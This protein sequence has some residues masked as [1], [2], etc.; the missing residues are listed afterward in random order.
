MSDTIKPEEID[1]DAKIDVTFTE[2]G[3]DPKI[4]KALDDLGYV[5][6]TPIQAKGIPAALQQRDVLGIAQTGTG[7]TGAFT[8]PT[9]HKLAKG[10]AR[11]RMPRCIIVCPT[12][13]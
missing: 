7:K 12:K 9:M 2:L 13:A 5:T 1:A 4:L 6:P 3:L 8:L 10:R 11:A